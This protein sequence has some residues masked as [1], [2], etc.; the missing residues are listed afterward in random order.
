ME[1]DFCFFDGDSIRHCD[2]YKYVCHASKRNYKISVVVSLV[3]TLMYMG[4]IYRDIVGSILGLGPNRHT[5]SAL[6]VNKS[7]E[8]NK[9]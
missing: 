9:F 1:A 6:M 2:L 8:S 7:T 5:A 3:R 4:I